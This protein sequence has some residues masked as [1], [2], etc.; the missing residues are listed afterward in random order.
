MTGKSTKPIKNK[1][2]IKIMWP[3]H[4]A[5]AIFL[6]LFS[7]LLAA[8]A[9]G[10]AQAQSV[11]IQASVDK[12]EL[13]LDDHL[14]LSVVIEGS[15]IG[16]LPD[17]ELPDLSG[18][19]IVNSYQ[20]SNFSWINGKIS[21]SKTI[22]YILRPETVGKLTIGAIKLS[23]DGKTYKTEPISVVVSRS[24]PQGRSSPA[25]SSPFSP[26]QPSRPLS[27]PSPWPADP[28][29]EEE[30][31]RPA[32]GNIF[33]TQTVNKHKVYVGEQVILTFSFF[34]RI[35][36]WQSPTY[37]PSPLE[38]FW[39]VELDTPERAEIKTIDGLPYRVQEIKKALFPIR[40][41]KYT[42]GPATLTYQTGFFSPPRRLKTEPISI[43][44]IPLPEEG[45]PAN[46]SG[47]VGK[48]TLSAQVDTPK[49]IQN[50]P[51]TLNVK[52]K[53][54]GYIEGLPEPE[55]SHLEGFQKYDTTTTQ[56]LIK[57]NE[58]RGEKCFD[59][60]LIPRLAGNLQIP[61]LHFSFFNPED[62]RYHTLSTDPILVSIAPA[63]AGESATAAAGSGSSF[64]SS[65]GLRGSKQEV[66]PSRMDIRYIKE[67][68]A[69][70]LKK[71]LFLF[72]NKVF[73]SFLPA[74][75]LLLIVCFLLDRRMRKF[76]SDQRYARLRRAGRLA[77]KKLAEAVRHDKRG[78]E[79]EFYA[80]VSKSLTEY[81]ADKL[82]LQ[83][84]GLTSQQMIEQL[85]AL[86]VTE[87]V[88][89]RLQHC[90]DECDYARFAPATSNGQARK[91]LLT[92]AEEV[93]FSLE[94][95]IGEKK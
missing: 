73:L 7:L 77:R 43:E 4:A 56:N 47:A 92:E 1:T 41:G 76:Q 2:L 15:N 86:G 79:K 39:V 63:A 89:T 12:T 40:A 11:S 36:L 78:E 62:G 9:A 90:L 60:L 84:A 29:A 58:L 68:E 26:R 18:F 13:S 55:L 72:R 74:P 66:R 30:E 38:G 75:L 67:I 49:G 3:P 5:K 64:G 52:I 19:S 8:T 95:A 17:P 83:A 27:P 37:Q 87:E 50:E 71:G 22:K 32:R 51:I 10:S 48:F 65:G 34:R 88:L 35:D 14:S 31:E 53:G 28:W 85:S 6:I 24:A 16:S 82:N 42:I 44:V 69:K 94:K 21:V 70:S 20:G 54:V 57:Q 80:A 59:F 23:H 33:I 25:P 93:I 46:F 45:K 81:V 61:S 91:N